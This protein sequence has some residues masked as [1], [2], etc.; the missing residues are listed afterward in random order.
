[1]ARSRLISRLRE[2]GIETLIHYPIPPHRQAAY[3]EENTKFPPQLIAEQLAN[4]VLSLPIHPL[5]SNEHTQ[6]VVA[7]LSSALQ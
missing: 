6:Q 5:Q 2:G 7:A 1:V 3:I 4:E